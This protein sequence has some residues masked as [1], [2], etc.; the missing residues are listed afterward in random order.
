MRLEI[1]S[2]NVAH[3]VPSPKVEAA[4]VTILTADQI[5]EV[6]TNLEGYGGRYGF[7][8]LHSIAALAIG[9]GMRRGEICGLSWGAV[10]L[11]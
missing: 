8:P 9:T 5:A 11:N 2:R 1:V 6:P 4:E 7:L 3:T 10:D